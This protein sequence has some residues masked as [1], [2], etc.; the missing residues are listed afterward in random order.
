MGLEWVF[1]LVY[2][3]K[4]VFKNM[5]SHMCICLLFLSITIKLIKSKITNPKYFQKFKC[6][7]CDFGHCDLFE[8]VILN[9]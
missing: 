7:N 8:L 2:A 1:R 5:E 3:T 9:L 4:K 6:S